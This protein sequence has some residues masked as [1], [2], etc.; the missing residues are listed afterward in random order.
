MVLTRGG[1]TNPGQQIWADTKAIA[2]AI[3]AKI[4]IWGDDIQ[5]PECSIMSYNI[6]RDGWFFNYPDLDLLY[7]I[8]TDASR[9]HVT[10]VSAISVLPQP[11][12]EEIQNYIYV[13]DMLDKKLVE[14]FDWSKYTIMCYRD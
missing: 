12:A 13:L 2:I 10:I 8:F 9:L 4:G 7:N 5:T 1:L 3:G 11:I 14:S 6:R